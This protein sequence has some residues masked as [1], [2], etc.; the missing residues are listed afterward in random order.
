MDLSI[1]GR[2]ASDNKL[3]RTSRIDE[4]ILGEQH[5]HVLFSMIKELDHENDPEKITTV[6]RS[7]ELLRS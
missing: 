6:F 2:I 7:M 3:S 1:M 5:D 4:M